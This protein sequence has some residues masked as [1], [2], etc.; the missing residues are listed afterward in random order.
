M[1]A[2]LWTPYSAI[3]DYL[4]FTIT[5]VLMFI[6]FNTDALVE[7]SLK[8]RLP[9]PY[10]REYWE[11][12]KKNLVSYPDFLNFN[13]NGF[14]S[15]LLSCEYCLNTVLNI[16]IYSIYYFLEGEFALTTLCINIIMGWILYPRMVKWIKN[17]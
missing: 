17:E 5:L 15:R 10:K 8:F 1:L 13:V 4:I 9:L 3:D 11:Y 6:W 2:S 16:V 12:K 14:T 7:Y